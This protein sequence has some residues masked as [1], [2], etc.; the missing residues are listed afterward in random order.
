MRD[1]HECPKCKYGEVLHVPELRE[2]DAV[3]A[4]LMLNARQGIVSLT[5]YGQLEVY[6]CRRC[7]FCE[8]YVANPRSLTEMIPG[9]R[10]LKAKPKPPYR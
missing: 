9:A 3:V 6:V 1:T 10:L 7:G 2:G 4:S 5:R 8:V